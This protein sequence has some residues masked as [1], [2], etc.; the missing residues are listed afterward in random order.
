M[1]RVGKNFSAPNALFSRTQVC[2]NDKKGKGGERILL[3]YRE[4]LDSL[5]AQEEELVFINYRQSQGQMCPDHWHACAE[6]LFVFGGSIEQTVNTTTKTLSAGDALLVSSGDIHGTLART[7]DCYVGVVQFQDQGSHPSLFL[8]GQGEGKALS[9]LF[10]RLHEEATLCCP[11]YRLIIRG[12]LLESLGLLE[13]WGEPLPGCVPL[14][15]EALKWEEYIREHLLEGVSLSSAAAF[16]GYSESHFSRRF[17]QLTGMSFRSYLEEARMEAAR[18]MLL[19]GLSL[20][21]VSQSL[22]YDGASSFS[23][24]FKRKFHQTPGQYQTAQQMHKTPQEM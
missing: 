4:P 23:R 10:S 18:K 20:W 6:L 9:P 1:H 16:A 22:G 19:E 5:I 8:S 17:R 21:E 7:E 13:R 24:A 11:G 14:S 12:L 3:S 15:S 2:Y